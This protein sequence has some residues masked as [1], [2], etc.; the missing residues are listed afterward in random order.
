MSQTLTADSKIDNLH[1]PKTIE[2][3][4]KK[5]ESD[6]NYRLQQVVIPDWSAF[7]AHCWQPS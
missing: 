4:F 3:L 1:E 6:G 2:D 5:A 7:G